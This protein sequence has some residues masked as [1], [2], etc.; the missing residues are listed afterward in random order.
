MAGPGVAWELPDGGYSALRSIWA[1]S[2]E[3]RPARADLAAARGR[4][5]SRRGAGRRGADHGPRRALRLRRAAALHRVRRARDPHPGHARALGRG[6]RA[7]RARRRPEHRRGRRLHAARPARGGPLRLEAG[8]RRR[9]SAA[10]RSSP[11]EW[12]LPGARRFRQNARRA[13]P[14]RHL[15][16]RRRAH[17]AAD[18][19]LRQLP[20]RHRGHAGAARDGDGRRR[21]PARRRQP[22]VRARVRADQRGAL[23]RHPPRRARAD[24]GRASARCIASRRP[25]STACTRTRR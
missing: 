22:A 4:A 24:H 11:L 16:F 7:R 23:P 18:R 21:R 13:D 20:G 9:R 12:R 14:R 3:E 8:R 2:A 5:R 10:T 15:R 6:R 25:T 19:R 1:I 17:L